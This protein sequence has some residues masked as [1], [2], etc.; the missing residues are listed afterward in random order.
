VRIFV[1]IT[2]AVLLAGSV[3]A[4]S[5]EKIETSGGPKI[6]PGPRSG[7]CAMS[8]VIKPMAAAEASRS[9]IGTGSLHDVGIIPGKDGCPAG[10]ELIEIYMDDEDDDNAD[11]RSGW[12]GAIEQDR[13]TRFKFCRVDG[14][15][16]TSVLY[17]GFAVLQLST[18]CPSGSASYQRTFENERNH[19]ANTNSSSFGYGISPNWQYGNF[20]QLSVCL[21]NGLS[22]PPYPGTWFPDFG[23]EY[24]V[25]ASQATLAGAPTYGSLHIDDEDGSFINHNQDDFNAEYYGSGLMMAIMSGTDNTDMQIAKV[26]PYCQPAASPRINGQPGPIV[27]IVGPDWPIILDG[28]PSSCADSYFVSIQLSDANWARYGPEAMRWL[29]AAEYSRY[30][31]LNHFNI[32]KFAEDQWFTFV[33]GQY[34][35]VKLAVGP[36]WNEKTILIYIAGYNVLTPGFK[37]ELRV[38]AHVQSYGDLVGAQEQ[39]VGTMGLA[40]RLEGFSVEFKPPIPDLG[41][42]YMAH[43]ANIGDTPW[44]AAPAFVGTRGEARRA[45]GFAAR[46]TGA[47]ASHYDVFYQ[48]HMQGIGNSPILTG[49]DFCGTRG[50]A[51]RIEALRIW[52]VA[53]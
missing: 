1:A 15:R 17:S 52:I 14:D 42:E 46:V 48:C 22:V 39:W 44:V 45:E 13:N 30:G 35:R 7:C 31:P 2:A 41:L 23:V 16:F 53:K 26:M 25:F 51:R 29:T 8:D 5:S 27:D 28:S 12:I 40:S 34:Y 36:T 47:N 10:S 38:L 37:P 6:E 20:T 21:F 9:P 18:T 24:G 43:L 50:E 11:S 3:W 32:K 33:P 49:P 4:Q 19:N